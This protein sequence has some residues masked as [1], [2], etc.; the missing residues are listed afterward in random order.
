MLRV[1]RPGAELPRCRL[2]GRSDPVVVDRLLARLVPKG[3]LHGERNAGVSRPPSRG[4]GGPG[5]SSP[6][7]DRRHRCRHCRPARDRGACTRREGGRSCPGWPASSR[8]R[9]PAWPGRRRTDRPAGRP[10][11]RRRSATGLA[12]SLVPTWDRRRGQAARRRPVRT[13]RSC[14]ARAAGQSADRPD[15]GRSRRAQGPGPGTA[16]RRRPGRRTTRRRWA[17]DRGRRR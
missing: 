16:A 2:P 12:G 6:E 15:A 1:P 4:P 9:G 5:S 8:R 3:G 17:C 11:P 10:I 14:A 13:C 7:P